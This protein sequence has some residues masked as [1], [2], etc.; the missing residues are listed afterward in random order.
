MTMEGNGWL[1]DLYENE[2]EDKETGEI[3]KV[4]SFADIP[5]NVAIDREKQGLAPAPENENGMKPVMVLSP[6]DLVYVPTEEEIKDGKLG[7]SIDR[8]RIYKMVSAEPGKCYFIPQSVASVIKDKVEFESH[9]KSM[10]SA[11]GKVFIQKVCVPVKV[12]RLGH[13]ISINLNMI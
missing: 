4:R 3:K 12:D 7:P 13:I 8:D 11:D 1:L 10:K 6:G 2:A 9:N 5:L